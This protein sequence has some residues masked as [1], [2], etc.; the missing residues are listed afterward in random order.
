MTE[1][2]S[3]SDTGSGGADL[4]K[5]Q[6]HL[7]H[8][9]A[10]EASRHDGGAIQQANEH[11]FPILSGRAASVVLTVLRPGGIREPPGSS[12]SIPMPRSR[13]TTS[14]SSPR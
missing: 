6:I 8:L 9:T 5:R 12:S 4:D 3:G 2:L 7:F 10:A 14:A 13:R 11:T 1:N